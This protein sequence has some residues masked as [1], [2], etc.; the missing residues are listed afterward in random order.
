M[1]LCSLDFETTGLDTVNDRPIELGAVLY[2]T[3]MHKCLN[4]QGMLVQTNVPIDA[5][6][7]GLTNIHPV[8][9]EKF[10][11][12]SEPMLDVMLDMV[13][14]SD[15]VIGYNV[16]RF[17]IHIL[18]EWAK[19][20]GKEVAP[21]PWIDLFVDMP[22]RVPRGKLAHVMADHGFINYFP[23]SAIFDAFGVLLIAS[24]YDPELLLQR[25]QSP[26]VVLRSH[27]A[28]HENDLVKKAP[29]Q[30]RWNGNEKFW[31]KAVKEQDV[32]E[33]LVEA[34]FKISIEKNWTPE[35]LDN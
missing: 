2:S 14:Q 18:N 11:Y 30:F 17:D 33:I 13:E 20:H 25:S 12:E 19:R 8:A 1:I 16:K 6:I 22:W 35:E 24:K 27:Q 21:K 34:P 9:V 28:R 26:V 15:A 7:T 5:T 23:H 31:W 29:F 4:T 3:G 32:A 10:G